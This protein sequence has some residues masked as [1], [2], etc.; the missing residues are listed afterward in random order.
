MK[1]VDVEVDVAP[2][3]S[4]YMARMKYTGYPEKY[5]VDT[6]VRSL[7]I[8]HKMIKEDKN[9]QRPIY[10]PK[11]WNIVA[12]K[13]E[14]QKKKYDWS[15]KG[16]HIA[17]IFIPPTPNSELAKSLKEI[18]DHEAEGGVLFKIIETAGYSMKRVL[19]T[20][21][22]L[23][24]PGCSSPG[25]LPCEGGRGEGDNC[26]GYGVNYQLECQLCPANAKSVYIGESS[27]NLYTR[28]QEHLSNYRRGEPNSFM[29]RHQASTHQGEEPSYKA[30]VTAKTRDCLT[31]QVREAV[32]LRRS[33]VPVLNGKSE[34][35]QPPL[36]RVQSEIERG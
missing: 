21:N 25:C 2:V 15:T 24:S 10:R 28:T 35:H 6:L 29:R 30:V 27:R 9:G 17:P 23:Q 32:L 16:G 14:K 13:K 11:D 22:P 4:R 8:Y 33:E 12:R 1:L 19:Q 5:R 18:A 36:F 3:I 31:R 34:W 26:P 20:S 7:R